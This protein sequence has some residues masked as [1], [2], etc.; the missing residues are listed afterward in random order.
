MRSDCVGAVR[1]SC[2]YIE[3]RAKKLYGM[4][5]NSG[6]TEILKYILMEN[7]KKLLTIS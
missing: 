5:V 3:I 6:H 7:G 1:F 2:V 4:Y